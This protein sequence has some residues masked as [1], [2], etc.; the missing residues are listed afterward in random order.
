MCY[1]PEWL[2]NTINTKQTR[3]DKANP[4][5]DGD[6]KLPGLRQSDLKERLL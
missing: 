1:R 2:I 4:A 6:A 5:K 3:I